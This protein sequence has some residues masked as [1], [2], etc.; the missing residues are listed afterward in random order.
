[1]YGDVIKVKRQR[2][3]LFKSFKDRRKTKDHGIGDMLI[4]RLFSY[5]HFGIEV[6]DDMV[7]HFIVPSIRKIKEGGVVHDSL[8]VFKKDGTIEALSNVYNKYTKDEVVQ[9][10]YSLL[11]E[12]IGPYNIFIN[13]CEHFAMWCATDEKI[14]NQSKFM[15]SLRA[16]KSKIM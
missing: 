8:E 15:V 12:N 14:S 2:L 4:N 13:N 10:A 7:I 11:G 5:T 16:V 6:E 3:G 1:M 9:R